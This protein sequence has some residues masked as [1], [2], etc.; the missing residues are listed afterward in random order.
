MPIFW[1]HISQSG[2]SC[3]AFGL[4]LST[5]HRNSHRTSAQTHNT[6]TRGKRRNKIIY[7]LII[8]SGWL[9]MHRELLQNECAPIQ[10]I[11]IAGSL[12]LCVRFWCYSSFLLNS[13]FGICERWLIRKVHETVSIKI[14]P[15]DRV[16]TQK[17]VL[18]VRCSYNTIYLLVWLYLF[19]SF[20]CQFH[21]CSLTHK[22]TR[23]P[24]LCY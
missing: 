17:C 16:I 3:I 13:T 8:I 22:H 10:H 21:I 6:H 23:A 1:A 4:L 18:N 9:W 7:R 20:R 2:R 12:C 15:F 14:H 5:L 11:Q 24:H 19:W